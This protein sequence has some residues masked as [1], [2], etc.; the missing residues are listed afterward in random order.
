MSFDG[1]E[2][3]L[4]AASSLPPVKVEYERLKE[5]AT[6]QFDADK[7]FRVFV[8]PVGGFE[9]R[10][11]NPAKPASMHK[12]ST[13][14][15]K[16]G[17]GVFGAVYD[18]VKMRNPHPLVKKCTSADKLPRFVEY[19]FRFLFEFIIMACMYPDLAPGCRLIVCAAASD[20]AGDH[21]PVGARMTLPKLGEESLKLKV[22]K[23]EKDLSF[24]VVCDRL[25]QFL[26][27]CESLCDAVARLH[28]MGVVHLDIKPENIVVNDKGECKLIDFGSALPISDVA[29]YKAVLRTTHWYKPGS[30]LL[31]KEQDHD[32]SVDV[33]SVAISLMEKMG[34]SSGAL[35]GCL[36]VT[37]MKSKT[38]ILNVHAIGSEDYNFFNQQL[39]RIFE[40]DI[41]KFMSGLGV[42]FLSA[43]MSGEHIGYI[44]GTLTAMSKYNKEERLSYAE[45]PVVAEN[46]RRIA[47]NYVDVRRVRESLSVGA[48]HRYAGGGSLAASVLGID[49]AT[50]P[51]GK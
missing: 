25:K 49:E 26:K 28:Q 5:A 2:T 3:N 15:A 50:P 17:E 11:L 42:L 10:P 41:V 9:I 44:I 36:A 23:L 7:M 27:I 35:S 21:Y 8:N 31:L 29:T 24:D 22:L 38:K 13:Q 6:I 37:E 14:G 32:F 18:V 12:E 45:L 16:L 51:S 30:M 33:Y 47:V 43:G 19:R 46:F 4:A 39:K 40:E 20:L 48:F 34:W 1:D